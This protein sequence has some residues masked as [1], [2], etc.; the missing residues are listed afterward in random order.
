MGLT[1]RVSDATTETD[2]LRSPTETSVPPPA[3]ADA[4]A[5]ATAAFTA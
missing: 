4:Y 5:G 1:R 2:A 3:V